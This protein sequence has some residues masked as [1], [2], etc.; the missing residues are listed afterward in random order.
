MHAKIVLVDDEVASIGTANMDIRSFELNYEII[1]VLYESNTVLDI[2]MTLNKIL[3]NLQKLHGRHFKS[4]VFKNACLNHLCGS[5]PST[6]NSGAI[7]D[8]IGGS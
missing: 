8:A 2:K 3:K 7:H 1:A 4:E 5:F 6:V